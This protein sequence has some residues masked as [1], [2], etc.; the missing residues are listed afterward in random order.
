LRLR[1]ARAWQ[2]LERRV[3][4]AERE[5]AQ[6]KH[7]TL[8]TRAVLQLRPSK[9]ANI[10]KR[11]QRQEFFWDV[12]Q[13]I[14][15]AGHECR[16]HLLWYAS[17]PNV[18][19]ASVEIAAYAI[20]AEAEATHWWFMG[21]RRLFAR[22][23]NKTG[24]PRT[25][26]V[27]DVGTSTGANLR[28]LRDLGFQAA[29]GLDFSQEAIRYCREKGLGVVRQ[30]DACDM[31]FAD[32]SF[33]LVLATDIIEH[34]DDDMKALREIGRVL[35]PGGRV[36][37][38]V[39]AFPILWGLQD[40]VSQHKRRYI[41]RDLAD[42]VTRAGF[43]IETCYYFNFLLF[44]PILVGRRL[45]DIFRLNVQSEAQ[46]NSPLLNRMLGAIFAADVAMAPILRPP[47]GVSIL[48]VARKHECSRQ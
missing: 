40:R 33:N 16:F 18:G 48:I 26:R 8:A 5:T 45:I 6:R 12:R 44:L 39:P 29:D 47:F 21:R 10:W 11:V 34:V 1:F 46:L 17:L 13:G 32:E 25:S 14:A 27:L 7:E 36:L 31:P 4:S 41:R 22:E 9:T 43:S 38:T 24:L 2:R 37:I 23:I 35:G 15:V 20:E 28:L 19:Q 30:G 3:A 42:R